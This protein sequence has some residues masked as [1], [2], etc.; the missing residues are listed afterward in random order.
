M[1]CGRGCDGNHKAE[2]HHNFKI[3]QYFS[4]LE[5]RSK[6]QRH[7][8]GLGAGPGGCLPKPNHELRLAIAVEGL[9][10]V[11]PLKPQIISGSFQCRPQKVT[12]D[13]QPRTGHGTLAGAGNARDCGGSNIWEAG[14]KS[15]T[16]ELQEA[17][18]YLETPTIIVFIVC[19]LQQQ[20]CSSELQHQFLHDDA[21]GTS[22]SDHWR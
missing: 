13:W 9:R 7:M 21:Y 15:R 18:P 8:E 5:L 12:E 6:W 10:G 14:N 2:T 22:H 17:E 1:L 11:R 20:T 4:L 16:F 19:L 3:A